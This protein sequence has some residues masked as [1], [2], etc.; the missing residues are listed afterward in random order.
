MATK[1]KNLH[2]TKVDFVDEGANPR[3]DIKLA[4][5][6]DGAAGEEPEDSHAQENKSTD[7][8]KEPETEPSEGLFKRFLKWWKGGNGTVQKEAKSFDDVLEQ[9]NIDNIRREV[10]QT[11][12]ALARSINSILSDEEIDSATAQTAMAESL[13]QFSTAVAGYIPSWASC[14]AVGISI[15][16]SVDEHT[17]ADLQMDMIAY[18]QL[19]KII[20]K[21]REKKGELEDM[22]KIDKSK[23]TPEEKAQYE[24]LVKKYSVDDGVEKNA[25]EKK[26]EEKEEKPETVETQKSAA[27]KPNAQDEGADVLKGVVADLRKE[28]SGLKDELLTEQLSSV[29]KKYEPLG[30]KPEDMMAILKKAKAAGMYDDVIAAY[31]SALEAQKSSGIFDEIGK[32][33][34]GT[35]DHSD[36]ITKARSAAEELRKSNPNMTSAQALD[37]VLLNDAELRKEFDQ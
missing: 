26:T 37:Q 6:K 30:K 32:S 14:K 25:G 19:G 1:L 28:I 5:S 4:K 18:D 12:E 21:S 34:E 15:S 7:P 22:I 11:T 16:K 9:D 17:E 10:W 3:A 31:D 33:T 35:A 27:T 24:E 13:T 36:A 8:Q 23:M 2:V 20:E 29:A